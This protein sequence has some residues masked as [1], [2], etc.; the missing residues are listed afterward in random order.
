MSQKIFNDTGLLIDD[1]Y[2]AEEYQ[3]RPDWD[4]NLMSIVDT[5]QTF[6]EFSLNPVASGR[7]PDRQVWFYFP[8]LNLF[9]QSTRKTHAIIAAA[10]TLFASERWSEI[11]D[12][13]EEHGPIYE[14]LA[15]LD[16][17][18]VRHKIAR[19]RSLGLITDTEVQQ[20]SN[21]V[22]HLPNGNGS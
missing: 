9:F 20:L 22:S 6:K 18:K 17:Q 4:P 3:E 1:G 2:S 16:L 10:K 11:E 5:G 7:V 19:A 14:F 8:T 15:R 12:I 13:L 21:L